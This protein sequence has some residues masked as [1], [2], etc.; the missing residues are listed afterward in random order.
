MNENN[1]NRYLVFT[2]TDDNKKVLANLQN[3]GMKLNILLRQ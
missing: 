3:F 1:E 2:S